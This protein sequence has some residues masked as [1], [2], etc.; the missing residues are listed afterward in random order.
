MGNS[1]KKVYECKCCNFETTLLANWK[2]HIK[3]K[4][5]LRQGKE[6]CYKCDKCNYSTFHKGDYMKHINSSKC[7]EIVSFN[8]RD[9]KRCKNDYQV[10]VMFHNT[11]VIKYDKIDKLCDKYPNN[12]EYNKEWEKT[13]KKKDKRYEQKLK[14][15]KKLNEMNKVLLGLM[16][17]KVINVRYHFKMFR[18]NFIQRHLDNFMDDYYNNVE[19]Y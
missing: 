13:L 11:Q 4:K 5:H 15:K 8:R 3:T 16:F 9:Y 14:L 7:K 19:L 17:Q 6:T 1:E 10:A 12:A 2:Q 18:Y